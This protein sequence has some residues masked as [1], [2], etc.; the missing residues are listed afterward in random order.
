V[1]WIKIAKAIVTIRKL[2]SSTVIFPI[3]EGELEMKITDVK[4]S[5]L[6]P[7]MQLCFGISTYPT[8]FTLLRVLTDEGIE[9]DFIK[10]GAE[11]PGALSRSLDIIRQDLIGQ[12][13]F[14]REKI[15]MEL[16]FKWRLMGNLLGIVD[17][18]LWDI[19]GKALKVPV[20]KLLGARKEKVLAYASTLSY[21]TDK[22]FVNLALE[23]KRKGYKA[24]KF[25]THQNWKK[26][27]V[28][29]RTIREA[30]G[31]KMILACDPLNGADRNGALKLGRELEK[32]DFLWYED[33]IPSSDM[34]GLEELCRRLDIDIVV[35][36]DFSSIYQ[37][38]QYIR[39]HATDILR[40]MTEQGGITGAMKVA[41][42]AECF[43]MKCEPC[44]F[45]S[46][47]V[48]AA[49]LHIELANDN[50]RFYEMPVSEG[51]LDLCMKDVARIDQDGFIHAPAKPGLGY[52]IDWDAVEKNTVR[53]Y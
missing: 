50:C 12:D 15:M 21:A 4:V 20:Y 13:P 29:A 34:D 16:S 41:H 6:K 47:L 37:H 22:E 51:M 24:I 45:G 46:M 8:Q 9:G 28:L 10:R 38:A 31:D 27:I 1:S 52:D 11:D 7:T 43:G 35:G 48:Q 23:C 18:L 25:H 44:N 26:D 36:E 53:T 39:R 40:T 30:V 42:L 19:A 2:D 33:P 49:H 3:Q 14:D 5:V 32:L 17:V